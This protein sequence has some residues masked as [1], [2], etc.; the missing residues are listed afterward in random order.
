M[1]MNSQ[2]YCFSGTGDFYFSGNVTGWFCARNNH[3]TV[4]Y[5]NDEG[6]NESLGFIPGTNVNLDGDNLFRLLIQG[7]K[8]SNTC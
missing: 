2:T 4:Y 3:G 6:K 7:S 1:T 5:R 8:G